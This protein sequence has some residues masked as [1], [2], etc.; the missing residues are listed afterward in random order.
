M[1]FA[2]FP[3]YQLTNLPT[4]QLTNFPTSQLTNLPTYQLS[5]FPTYKQKKPEAKP[6]AFSFKN[7]NL[8]LCK[9]PSILIPHIIFC[10][11]TALQILYTQIIDY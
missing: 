7:P 4:F 2:F 5:N 1:P 6:P 11:A 9:Q 8:N 10:T 3:T